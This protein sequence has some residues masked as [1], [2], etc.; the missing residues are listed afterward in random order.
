MD[1]VL[2]FK[3]IDGVG[4]AL[5]D[6]V[7]KLVEGGQQRLVLRQRLAETRDLRFP[8]AIGRSAKGIAVDPRELIR[9]CQYL[10]L[11]QRDKGDTHKCC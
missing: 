10:L 11:C 8:L 1:D 6:L 2:K 9:Q 4:K 3:R 5:Q 7:D